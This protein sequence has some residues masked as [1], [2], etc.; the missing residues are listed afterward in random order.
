MEENITKMK[1]KINYTGFEVGKFLR[2]KIG[3]S[4]FPAKLQ[5]L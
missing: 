5:V 3:L 4:Q 2:V 1:G